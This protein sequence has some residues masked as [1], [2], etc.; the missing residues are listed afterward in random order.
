MHTLK[1]VHFEVCILQCTFQSTYGLRVQT[2]KHMCFKAQ[3]KV[4]LLQSTACKYYG[5]GEILCKFWPACKIWW[6]C[7][8]SNGKYNNSGKKNQHS[9]FNR[10]FTLRWPAQLQNCS[11]R[12]GSDLNKDPV[13][14]WVSSTTESQQ[15]MRPGV[16][17][18]SHRHDW[19]VI[20]PLSKLLLFGQMIAVELLFVLVKVVL[21][22][23]LLR[24]KHTFIK[25]EDS[26][27]Y[28]VNR[29][30]RTLIMI[31]LANLEI[32]VTK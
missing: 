3:F 8:S 25:G 10:V 23:W 7:A 13:K 32:I 26:K 21:L 14:F 11:Y 5:K 17:C 6:L 12:Q 29:T 9:K 24:S 2:L 31:N 19:L 15:L 18:R 20:G 4:C 1:Y 22:V 28:R 16:V 27:K 30:W